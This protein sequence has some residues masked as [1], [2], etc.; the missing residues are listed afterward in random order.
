MEVDLVIKNGKIVTSDSIIEAGVAIDKGKIIAIANDQALP[1]AGKTL[2]AGGGHILPGIIDEHV[3]LLDMELADLE[4]FTTGSRAAAAGGV[5]TVCEM[6]LCV[7]ATTSL[8]TLE[9]INSLLILLSGEVLFQET[10]MRSPKWL[11]QV[12]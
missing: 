4:N 9:E 12:L 6:P 2:D 7:P 10:S 1:A 5:T 11:M 8:E 3:H